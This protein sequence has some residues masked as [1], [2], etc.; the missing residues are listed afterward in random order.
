[1]NYQL[2]LHYGDSGA[3]AMSSAGKRVCV[4]QNIYNLPLVDG[5][6]PV[7]WISFVPSGSSN[8]LAWNDSYSVYESST[9]ATAGATI[10]MGTELAAQPGMTYTFEDGSFYLGQGT[11]PD[12]FEVVNKQSQGSFSFGLAQQVT[13]DSRIM[14]APIS[15]I[16]L[17]YSYAASFKPVVTLSVF[18]ASS[19]GDGG[20]V[21]SQVPGDAC[22]ITF[23]PISGATMNFVPETMTFSVGH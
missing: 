8:V 13:V 1:M 16:P 5:I 20:L 23:S 15:L 19:E 14:F 4:V 6:L 7:A 10:Q 2:T 18:V 12:Y 3:N 22:V 17:Q 21:L 11:S 9:P